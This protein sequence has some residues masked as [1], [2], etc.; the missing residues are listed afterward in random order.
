MTARQQMRRVQGCVIPD[1]N[2]TKL[3]SSLQSYGREILMPQRNSHA[4]NMAI[5]R[6][7]EE[8]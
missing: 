7:L 5:R 3:S 6:E 1:E 8:D 4:S 2:L